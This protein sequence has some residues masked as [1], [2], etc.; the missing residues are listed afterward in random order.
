MNLLNVR[1]NVAL[2][3]V[4]LSISSLI[5]FL[6]ASEK[7]P[8]RLIVTPFSITVEINP[9]QLPPRPHK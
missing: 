5:Y 7:V 3:S 9:T 8:I 6:A 4:G 1:R 2:I